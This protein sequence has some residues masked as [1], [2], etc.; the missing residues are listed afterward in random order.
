M[1][2]KIKK[3]STKATDIIMKT[4]DGLFSVASMFFMLR[5]ITVSEQDEPIWTYAL[6]AYVFIALSKLLAAI[7]SRKSDKAAF[8][9]NVCSAALLA[10]S[11][12]AVH[13]ELFSTV[14]IK[15]YVIAFCISVILNRVLSIKKDRRARNVVFN[16]LVSV[17]LL[18]FIITAILFTKESLAVVVVANVVLVFVS[19]LFHI[20]LISFSQMR[21][22]VIK[23]IIRKT[24]AAEII[25]GLALL[26]V[27]F[28]FVFQ[29][30]D[31]TIETYSDALWYCFAIVTTIGFGDF[32]VT[33]GICRTLSV[34]LGIYGIVVVA[35]IT[36]IIVNF[37]NEVKNDSEDDSGE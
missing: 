23:K 13:F 6:L 21:I 33:S 3:P 2:T 14:S 5:I 27:S 20:I 35:L 4:A 37:Y 31:P 1:K 18:F 11:G 8:V 19:D 24:Y 32:T 10:T 9:V 34:I 26:I 22:V 36:S 17:V 7:R 25:F 29:A 12:F 30:L 16:V 15:I 28:S